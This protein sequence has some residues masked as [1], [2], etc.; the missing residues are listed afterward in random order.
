MATAFVSYLQIQITKKN[1]QRNNKKIKHKT[2]KH[3]NKSAHKHS[4]TL[5]L[6]ARR[7]VATA[8]VSCLQIQITQ[9]TTK[10]T[11]KH[12]NK[13]AQSPKQNTLST[14]ETI[15]HVNKSAQKHSN[16]LSLIARRAVATAFVSGSELASE[17][18]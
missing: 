13:S 6:I 7:A 14:K 16:T 1:Y 2:I 18:L 11:I 12:V 9:K 3:V 5:S 17:P 4:N 10:E 8:L 15:K